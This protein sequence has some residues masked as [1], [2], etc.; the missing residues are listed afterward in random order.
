MLKSAWQ[1]TPRPHE[2]TEEG[3]H[4]RYSSALVEL[5]ALFFGEAA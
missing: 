2:L 3:W 1:E 4:E 5:L